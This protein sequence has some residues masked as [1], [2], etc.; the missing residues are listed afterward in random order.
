MKGRN[1]STSFW[2]LNK[3]GGLMKDVSLEQCLIEDHTKY[4]YDKVELGDEIKVRRVRQE[5]W[6]RT[7]LHKKVKRKGGY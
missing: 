3:K 4:I 2:P 5:I 6:N 7:L 1:G